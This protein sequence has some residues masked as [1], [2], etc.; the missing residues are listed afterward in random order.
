MP[1]TRWGRIDGFFDRLAEAWDDL[2][3]WR[4]EMY[5]EYHR[6]VQ[7]THVALKQAYRAAERA[8]QTHEAVRCAAGGGP[9]DDADRKRVCWAQFHDVLPGSSVQEV[10]DEVVPEL[11]GF[12]ERSLAAAASELGDDGDDCVFKPIACERIETIDGECFELPP[13]AG[14]RLSDLLPLEFRPVSRDGD[15]LD[16]GRVRVAFTDDG[17][18]ASL[19]IDGEAIEL[20]GPACTLVCLSDVPANYDAWD[21][22]RHTMSL[23]QEQLAPPSWRGR[24]TRP[25]GRSPS[26]AA[27]AGRAP[28]PSATPWRRGRPC[29]GSTWTSTGATNSR[30][31]S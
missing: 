6:G 7:T 22:D 18:V 25:G 1:R 2:P 28:R 10:Y 13:L 8:L 12:A 11:R 5:L 27:S 17:R 4:G 26:R 16:N 20:A 14:V 9:L 19:A 24:A 29:F 3:T 21:V 15:V 31:S 30:C 23:G